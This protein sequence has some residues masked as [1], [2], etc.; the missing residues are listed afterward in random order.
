MITRVQRLLQQVPATRDNVEPRARILKE[1]LPLAPRINENFA[2]NLLD[3]VLPT[4]DAM[5]KAA[6]ASELLE[7]AKLL[8]RS[9]FVAAHF[10]QGEYIRP[11]VQRFQ[12]L[13]EA[14]K[15][16]E[17]ISALD[18][19]AGQCFRGLRK[20]GMRDE[21]DQLLNFLAH[22]ILQGRELHRI[23]AKNEPQWPASLRAL[24]HVAA[25]WFYFSRDREADPVLE[26]ARS[27]LFRGDMTAKEKMGLACTYAATLG[28]APVEAAKK[29]LEEIFVKLKLSDDWSTKPYFCFTQLNVIETVV[30]AVA[31]DDF[32]LG[33]DARR[34][35]DD[36]EFLV[37]RRIHRDLRSLL[38]QH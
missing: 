27:F 10:D 12:G 2:K 30:L 4:F 8:E 29:S 16:K 28:Q 31:S 3:Q 35:L 17:G 19:L 34:W 20:L 6:D 15:G 22:G 25:G 26:A 23:D 24:L 37:R 38:G 11:L 13:L 18:S 9:L 14:Q 32:T 36:D 33:A 7:Q 21:I 1:V 5:A